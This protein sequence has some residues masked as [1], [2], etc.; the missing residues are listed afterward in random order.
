MLYEKIRQ[1]EAKETLF[2]RIQAPVS[3]L[4]PN[5]FYHV[6]QF[7]ANCVLIVSY[8]QGLFVMF[9]FTSFFLTFDLLI[10]FP[11]FFD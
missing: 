7:V 5:H 11:A 1:Y 6:L 9:R 10:P 4:H 2:P 3:V 8:F